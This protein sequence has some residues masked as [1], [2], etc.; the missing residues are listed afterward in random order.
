MLVLELLSSPPLSVQVEK[1][2]IHDHERACAYEHLNLLLHYIM[3]MKVRMSMDVV[4]RK[5][6]LH[7]LKQWYSKSG[8]QENCS[9][10]GPKIIIRVQGIIWDYIKKL[11]RKIMKYNCI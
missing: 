10:V 5:C 4:E 6:P 1:E 11:L 2:R 7:T 9:G 8:S 3:G